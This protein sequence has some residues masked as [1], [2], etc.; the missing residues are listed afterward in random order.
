MADERHGHGRRK[1]REARREN[2]VGQGRKEAQ[3]QSEHGEREAGA[4]GAELG[5]DLKRTVVR[6]PDDEQR[7]EGRVDAPRPGALRE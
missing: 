5:P 7:R 2:L 4:D 1:E 6:M 3:H